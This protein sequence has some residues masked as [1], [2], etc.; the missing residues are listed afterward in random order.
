MIILFL[1][2]RTVYVIC[3]QTL[4]DLID[5]TRD[6]FTRYRT[7]YEIRSLYRRYAFALALSE[8]QQKE[9]NIEG[10]N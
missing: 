9:G 2:L 4:R 6:G 8:N 10:K 7:R 5:D 1:S 3:L